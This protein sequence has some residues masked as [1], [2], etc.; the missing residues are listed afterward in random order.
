[1]IHQTITLYRPVGPEELALIAQSDWKKFPPRLPEQPIFYPVM[2]EEYAI[3]IARD[4]NVPASG[5]GFVTK[6]AVDKNYLSKFEIQNVGGA[7]H[8]ELW[9][10]AEE[11]ETFNNHIVGDIEVTQKFFSKNQ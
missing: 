2:N 8:N 11:L 10:M 7:I 6:F 9:I 4:W 1:M 5:S 3:Q